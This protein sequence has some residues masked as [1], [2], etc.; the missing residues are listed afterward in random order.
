MKIVRKV[1][2]VAIVLLVSY[3]I[4][5]KWMYQTWCQTKPI[6]F[7]IKLYINHNTLLAKYHQK[8]ESLRATSLS[9]LDITFNNMLNSL[10]N[11]RCSFIF[12]TLLVQPTT[13][14]ISTK[15]FLQL[16]STSL[17]CPYLFIK[18]FLQFPI[19]TLFFY[20]SALFYLPSFAYSNSYNLQKYFTY[21][22]HLV[23]SDCV[24]E[25]MSKAALWGLTLF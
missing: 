13:P 18:L 12:I 6:K 15:I 21:L 25:P 5:F 20:T 7:I 8:V 17:F 19:N 2:V 22:S 4:D 9:K 14:T 24:K 23:N 10:Q 3:Y 1:Q 11:D 16:I